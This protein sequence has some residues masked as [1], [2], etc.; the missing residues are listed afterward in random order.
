MLLG[1]RPRY[2][3]HD[4]FIQPLAVRNEGAI[5]R[6]R[7]VGHSDHLLRRFGVAEVLRLPAGATLGPCLQPIADDAW[8]LEAGDAELYW[9]DERHGSPTR[10]CQHHL[11]ARSP[12]LWLVPFG[13]VFGLRSGPPCVLVHLS[14]HESD[15]SPTAAATPWP[16]DW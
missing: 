6:L 1:D 12:L 8:V 4:L 14:T 15:S 3:I 2:P 11:R 5:A 10:G 16:E 13:V 9:R 7:L